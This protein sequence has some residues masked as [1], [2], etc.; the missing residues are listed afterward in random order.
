MLFSTRNLGQS[1]EEEEVTRV[2]E[3]GRGIKDTMKAS[4]IVLKKHTQLW[5]ESGH[6]DD[7]GSIQKTKPEKSEGCSLTPN[8]NKKNTPL[9]FVCS[10][11][12]QNMLAHTIGYMRP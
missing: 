12:I 1:I 4:K 10:V 7:V 8:N 11:H 5:K 6:Q 9:F 2:S 3:A